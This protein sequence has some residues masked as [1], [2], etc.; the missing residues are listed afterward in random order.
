[1]KN[2]SM[3]R[4]MKTIGF[5]WRLRTWNAVARMSVLLLAGIGAGGV[6]VPPL[7]AETWLL[8]GATVHTVASDAIPGGEV[9]VRDGKIAAV[10]KS[11]NATDVPTIDLTGLQLYPGLI[12]LDTALGLK[13]I[14]AVRATVDVREVGDFT[15]DVFSW[16]AVNPD[17]ELLPVAR[18]N[19]VAY[20]EPAPQGGVVAGQSALVAL[21]GWTIEDMA[22]RKPLALHVYWPT[23]TLNPTPREQVRDKAGWQSLEDQ[24]KQR[25]ARLRALDDFFQ[26]ARAYAQ[27][28]A[29]AASNQA[30]AP[31][32]DPTWE[33]LLPFVRG[34]RP[35]VVHADEGRQIQAA[36]T[37]A[38]TN[39]WPIIL[40]GG[41]D[42]WRVAALL[43]KHQVPV[44]YEHIFT[45]PARDTDAYDVHFR[46]PEVLRQ[47][48]VTVIFSTGVNSASLVKNLPYEAA[49][50]VAFGYPAAEAVKGLTLYPARV[51]GMAGRLGSIEAGK[52]ATFFAMDGDVLDIRANVKRM[53]IA[54]REVSLESRHTRL[55]E[56]YR[57]RPKAR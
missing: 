34:E 44:I 29:A 7:A 12:A 55:Y 48:G 18:A 14:G 56:K 23:M 31:T 45:L 2:P 52:D 5:G 27:A 20:F 37:W 47:A 24:A 32:P 38:A 26:D 30:Q 28:K 9:L 36:V 11:V 57:H 53:W 17:S 3:T 15:P 42:A 43:A 46:A 35:L 1:M 19:G 13:E 6:L 16:W 4:N 25:A 54:G 49:Q 21:D 22:V 33:A 50:A 39:R 40:A 10:G 51:A 8:K 41:R